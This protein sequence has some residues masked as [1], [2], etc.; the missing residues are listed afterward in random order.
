MHYTY[1]IN[2]VQKCFHAYCVLQLIK[3]HDNVTSSTVVVVQCYIPG[4]GLV[5]M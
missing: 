1:K 5:E 2:L 4:R 3:Y